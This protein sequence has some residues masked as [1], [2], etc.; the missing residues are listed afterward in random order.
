MSGLD[1]LRCAVHNVVLGENNQ[2]GAN[3]KCNAKYSILIVR[4]LELIS[5]FL[6]REEGLFKKNS[7]AFEIQGYNLQGCEVQ[8]GNRYWRYCVCL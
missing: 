3:S 8:E 5:F 7:G 1:P 2:F 6:M 4:V